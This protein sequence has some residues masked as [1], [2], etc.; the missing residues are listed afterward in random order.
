MQD[1]KNSIVIGIEDAA[2]QLVGWLSHVDV[3]SKDKEL[4]AGAYQ[5]PKTPS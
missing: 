5:A 1:I 2:D 4:A 3:Q